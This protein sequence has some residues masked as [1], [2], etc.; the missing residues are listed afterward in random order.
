MIHIFCYSIAGLGERGYRQL[1]ARASEDRRSRADRYTHGEDKLRCIA[2][3]ALLRCA[4]GSA[5]YTVETGEF[6]KPHIKGMPGFHYNL[7]HSGDWVVLAFGD[8]QVGVD[9]QK[10]E[11]SEEKQRL[12]RRFFSPEEQ[13]YLFRQED[14]RKLRFYEIWTRKESWLKY[15]GTG[16]RK[17]LNSFSVFSPEL[18]PFFT[19][20]PDDHHFLTLC[21][22]A[23]DCRIHI[24]TTEELLQERKNNDTSLEYF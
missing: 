14:G 8:A 5:E 16:I 12:A 20:M 18:P 7:S 19:H 4:L 24:L 2:A 22:T 10:M 17:P 21:T 6:G 3:D 9:V 11:W 13:E 1:F 23:S 15:L